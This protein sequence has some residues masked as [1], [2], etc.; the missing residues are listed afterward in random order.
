[1]RVYLLVFTQQIGRDCLI[2]MDIFET[3]VYS[4]LFTVCK[5]ILNANRYSASGENVI[6]ICVQLDTLKICRN[7]YSHHTTIYI[8]VAAPIV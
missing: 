8:P 3:N 5:R 1:M 6:I 7:M 2:Y 4:D